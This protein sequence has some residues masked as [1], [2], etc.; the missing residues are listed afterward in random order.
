MDTPDISYG[1]ACSQ[2]PACAAD[3]KQKVKKVVCKLSDK[4][5][6]SLEGDTLVTYVAQDAGTSPDVWTFREMTKIFP[7]LNT[8][9]H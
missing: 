9:G 6:I 2:I 8:Q 7:E 5:Q 4:D 3:F 1:A